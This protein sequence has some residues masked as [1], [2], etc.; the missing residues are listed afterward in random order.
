MDIAAQRELARLLAALRRDG[1]QQSGLAAIQHP[2]I[3]GAPV[4]DDFAE[5]NL[6]QRDGLNSL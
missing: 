3:E 6:E 4:K 5:Q 2:L 1:R